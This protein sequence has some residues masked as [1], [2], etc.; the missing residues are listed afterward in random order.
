MK[1]MLLLCALIVGSGSVW[2]ETYTIG[3]GTASGSEGTYTNF[4]SVSGSVPGIVSFSTAQNQGTNTPAYNS[5][6]NDLRLYYHSGGNG[7]SITLTP[8]S[9]LKIT[10]VVMTTSTSPSVKYSVDGGSATSVSCSSNTYTISDIEASTSLT[11]Q[12]VNTSNTQ[13]RIKTIA[14]TYVS[15]SN[16]VQ[17]KTTIDASGIT[18]INR[19]VSTEAGSFS[20]SVTYGSPSSNVPDASVTWSSSD[21]DV[22]IINE[23]TGVVTLVA[24]GTTTITASYAG[25]AD[26]YAPSSDAY[27]LTVTNVDP[28]I[29]TIWSEDFSSYDANDVPNGGTNNYI[30][31]DGGSDTRIFGDSYAGGSAPELLVGKTSGKFSATISLLTATYGYSGD[32]TLTYKTNAKSL[33]VKSGTSGITVKGEASEGAGVTFSTVGTHTITFEGTTTANESINIIFSAGSDNVRLDDIV[34]IG[35]KEEFTVVATP[36]ISPAGGIVISGTEVTITCNTDGATIYYTTDGSTP[37]TSST[38]YNPAKKPTITTSATIKAFAVKA[39]L[40]DSDVATASYTIAEP[41]ATPTF[42]VAEGEVAKGTTVTISC[43]TDG[44]TIYY[45]TDGSTPT[46]SSSEYSGAI[47]INKALTIKAIAVK[48][49]MAN[50]DVA[51]ATY[52]IPD[53]ATLP[54]EYDGNG[55][56]APTG[57][58]V[59]GLGTYNN[60]PKMKFDDTGDYL[61]LKINEAPGILSFDIKGNGFSDGTFNVQISP[62]GSDYTNIATYTVLGETQTKTFNLPTSTRYIKWV[63]TKKVNGNV[64]L[65]NIGLTNTKKITLAAAC[66]DGSTY[67]GTYSLDAAFVVPDGLT[68]SEIKLLDGKLSLSNYDTDDVVPANTGVLVSSTTSGD[69]SVTLSTGGTSKLGGDNM[70]R[71]SG[72]AG[73]FADDMTAADDGCY[74]Y[75]LTMGD[76][77][78]GFWWKAD[79]GAGFYLAANKAY[80]AVPKSVGVRSFDLFG[81]ETGIVELNSH[82]SKINN[83]DSVYNLSGQRIVTPAKGLYIVNGKKYI[84]K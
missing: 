35:K 36:N 75:H 62:N 37:T 48:D 3:W 9:G 16:A 70:L 25:V 44:A 38:V 13:L 81:D 84:V 41:C 69:H 54:F 15:S 59:S 18:N 4:T 66:T 77:C 34:L 63:Y 72:D 73:V 60:S 49:G 52:T 21:E 2:A 50:S 6:N 32:L 64:A 71:P 8:A 26:T 46:T 5:N 7:G 14:I 40:T 31:T 23:T 58:T 83:F 82:Q 10:G 78:P 24:A 80:L 17:T 22:A 51:S 39:G 29:V 53:Y 55:T 19:F 28:D 11:I 43:D 67:Y 47:T 57:L 45:T 79:N 56:S 20:A 65:G 61:I 27:E 68:V 74:F 30:C 1:A 76:T 42:S 33:N 12:N